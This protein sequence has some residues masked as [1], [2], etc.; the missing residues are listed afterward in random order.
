MERF[1][2][3]I[4]REK[5][6][7]FYVET[8]VPL[9]TKEVETL[10]WLFAET[11]EPENFRKE[12]FLDSG[13]QEIVEIGPRLNFETAFSANAVSI[14]RSCGLKKIRRIEKSTR[15]LLP[16]ESKRTEFIGEHCDRMTECAYPKSLEKFETGIAPEKVYSAPLIEEGSKALK[17]INQQ[18]GLGM[19]E[20][21]IN[22]YHKLFTE[23]IGRNPTNVECFQLGQANSEHS[24]HWF[25]KG[26]LI[27]NGKEIP[28]TLFQIVKSTLEANPNNSVIAFKDNSSA[29]KGY[30]IRTIAPQR[31]GRCS[32]FFKKN[33][34]Y[35]FVFTAETHNFPSGVAPFPGAETGTGGRIRDVQATGKGAL[36]AAGIAGYCAG[37]LNM[38]DYQIPGENREFAYPENLACPLKILIEESNG[39]SDYGNKFGEPVIQGFT[40][41]FGIKIPKGERREWIKP[42]MFTGGIGQIDDRH[43][44]KQKP[45]QDMLIVQIGGP[46]YRI[47]MGGGSASSMIQ[48]QN[49]EDLDFNAVQRGDAEMEQKMN[50][51]IKACVE[52]GEENLILSIHDQ[53]AGGPCN[54]LTEIIEPAGGKIEIRN[55]K[56]GDQTMSV[57]E[58]WG[59]EYQERNALLINPDRIKEFQS[60]CSREKVNCEVLGKITGD[61][62]I[63]V[64]DSQNN[65]T[66]VDLNLSQILSN[67]PQKTFELER[68]PKKLAPLQLPENLTL[69]KALKFIF[70]LPSVGSK[71][72]LTRKV[73]R[74]VTGLIAQQQCC[75]P[76][77]LP[78]SDVSVI[79]QS[80]FGITGAAMAIGEQPIKMLVDPASGARMAVAE[81]LT[82]MC[83]ALISD[84]KDIKCSVNWMWSAKLPGEGALLYGAAVA[85]RDLMISL[86][87]A[88]DGGKDSL[89]MAAS[90]DSEIVK[91]P[92]QMV[93][94]AYAS[95]PDITKV[96][97]PDLKQPGKSKLMMIDLAPGKNRLGGSALAQ[98]FGQIG[99]ESPD[100][101]DPKLLG[102]A[103]QAVQKMIKE[104][105][106]LSG[107]DRSDGGLITSLAEMAISGNCGIKIALPESKEGIIAQLFSEELGLVLEYLPKNEKA[108]CEI[109]KN[110]NV[111]SAI[112]G[113]TQKEKQLIIKAGGQVAL[114]IPTATLLNWWESTSDRLEQEQ[115]NPVLAKEQARNHNRSAPNYQLTFKPKGTP[116]E[117]LLQKTKPK[118]AI[119]REEGSNGDREMASAF[120][121]AGFEPWDVAIT[122]LLNDKI[123]LFQFRGI[124]FVGGFSYADVLGSAKGWAGVI[125]FNSKLRQMFDEFYER[126][127]TFSF[128]VCNGCQ[129]MALLGWAPWKGISEKEQPR[130]VRN[131]S[132]RFESRW[133][134]VKITKSPSIMLK[135]MKDS[136]LGIW[137]AHGEGRLHCPDS[138][139]LSEVSQKNLT[140]IVYADDKNKPTE[141]YPFNPNGSPMGIAAL[142]SPDG[143][144]LAMMPHPERAFRL[145][146]W[147]YVPEDWKTE[148]QASPWLK[149]FQNARNWCEQVDMKNKKG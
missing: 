17:K 27:I 69:E 68:C 107:H 39:A 98:A 60:I 111:P 24:R 29:I 141:Q 128:G 31:P 118:V 62:K 49:K 81:A 14:C 12:S 94:S 124:A 33:F 115:V 103:F 44:K 20:W 72:Y 15:Y 18:M 43:I 3:K 99:D 134:T 127:N 104:N 57:V 95:M 147:P 59:A 42:I 101:D 119:I 56:A 109:L 51:V 121:A 10:K 131:L 64:Y 13:Q 120:Y 116:S 73:D 96:V 102:S 25:F 8:F 82:N 61:G 77:Q 145:W 6:L 106:I 41:T 74:S 142:C 136:C 53:G 113:E 52:M 37:N 38:P 123:S 138:K 93:I 133:V 91:A 89:S 112:L 66:P 35:N 114:D 149:M 36:V 54:V 19:D 23:T 139:I 45:K 137:I 47:G 105:L 90:V 63:V 71:G 97:T 100:V 28:E 79:A 11:F 55:I 50:R 87:I 32:P 58:I 80:H 122:D 85:M 132:E 84:I 65:S 110:S 2:R 86:G 4:G 92:G 146:Q 21:D 22:F 9:D 148:L 130:F 70:R 140:P 16:S 67:M 48:G 76:L 26:K 7:C 34:A 40:R 46:A 126:K 1:Y 5:E 144:H 75:G 78:V 125:K 135:N 83:W 143:R 88:A 108:I 30:A 117:I 129:L